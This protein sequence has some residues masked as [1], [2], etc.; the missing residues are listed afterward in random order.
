MEVVALKSGSAFTEAEVLGSHATDGLDK[1]INDD[2]IVIDVSSGSQILSCGAQRPSDTGSYES[3]VSTATLSF[4]DYRGD[5]FE[6][7]AASHS[8][9]E[10]SL[11]DHC[12]FL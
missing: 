11:M 10:R 9:L 3:L 12:K 4:R 2:S 5:V 7:F 1:V 8:A 6:S